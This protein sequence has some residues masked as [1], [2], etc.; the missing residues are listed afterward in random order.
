ME[1]GLAVVRAEYE[2]AAVSGRL[3]ML[4]RINNNGAVEVTESLEADPEAKVANL[5]RFGVQ[6]PMPKSFERIVY[7][8][9]GPIEN[10]SDRKDSQLLG[11]YDQTV[12]EQFY[13]YIR[14]QENGTK[15]DIRWWRIVDATGR[16][17]EVTAEEP[18]SASAL[19]Y[20]VST[21]DEGPVKIQRHSGDLDEDPVTNLLIDK[22]QMGLGCIN[23]WGAL[24]ASDYM[25]PYSGYTFRFVL[26]PVKVIR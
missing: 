3:S 25:L 9:R 10:Y 5:F 19:H 11:I 6:M 23:S 18:F 26:T 7:Y 1:D 2:I 13:P 17:L 15:T 4:Y 14:P 24:P 12:T 8:G 20:K 16:G 21:L 22:A